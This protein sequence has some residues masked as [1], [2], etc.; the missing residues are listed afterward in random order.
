[1]L[2]HQINIRNSFTVDVEDWF[3]VSAFRHHI[4]RDDWPGCEQRVERNMNRLLELMGDAGVRATCFVLGCVA[5]KSPSLVRSMIEAG[6]EVASHGLEHELVYDLAPGGFRERLHRSVDILRQI[7]GAPVLGFRA[8]SFSLPRQNRQWVYEIMVEAGLRY[9]SSVFPIRRRFYGHP[10]AP[11]IPY[12]VA[13]ASGTIREFP[14]P[15]SSF[16]GQAIPFGGGGYLRL[17]PYAVTVRMFRRANREGRPVVVYVH[18][19]EIDTE[20]PRQSVGLATRFRHYTNIGRVEG[21]LRRL[22]Q[23]FPFVPLRERLGDE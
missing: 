11:W 17:Y 13:T 3:H 21:R 20:Q 1:M 14:L 23:E 4:R 18:P 5:Q 8:A 6:H 9:D 2:R 10:D 7:V 22:W 15:V 12:D 19:W 16:L